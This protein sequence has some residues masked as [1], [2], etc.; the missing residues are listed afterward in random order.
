MVVGRQ[1][2]ARIASRAHACIA[3]TR[4]P[5]GC[6][7]ERATALP[8]PKLTLTSHACTSWV[9]GAEHEGLP[10][11]GRDHRDYE[12]GRDQRAELPITTTT[13]SVIAFATMAL[14]PTR[15]NTA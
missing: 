2:W 3:S 4:I 15:H 12:R 11:V 9:R 10:R 1:P 6:A 7:M 13:R 5:C 14:V 8:T